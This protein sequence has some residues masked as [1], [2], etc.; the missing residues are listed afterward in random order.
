[1][2]LINKMLQ[3]LDARSVEG[4]RVP[5][6]HG[7]VRA[8]PN[9]RS[10]SVGIWIALGL[11]IV[12]AA[13]ATWLLRGRA[14][15]AGPTSVVATSGA[16]MTSATTPTTTIPVV[17]T[18]SLAPPTV[19]PGAASGQKSIGLAPEF[20]LKMAADLNMVPLPPLLKPSKEVKVRPTAESSPAA[21]PPSSISITLSTSSKAATTPGSAEPASPLVLNR[22]VKDF[23]PQ[24]RAEN[25]Y[26]RATVL[27][28]QG[29]MP[30]AIDTLDQALMLD[31]QNSAARQTLVAL[32]IDSK[33]PDDAIRRMQEGLTLDPNQPALAMVL[34][35][36][37]VEKGDLRLA[38]EA[39]HRSL[40]HGVD[41]PEYL[42]FLAALLQRQGNH[43]EAI[44]R[45]VSALRKQPQNGVWWMGMGI[46]LQAENRIKEAL[47]AFGR[48]K[49]S[50]TLSAELLVY[51]DQKLNQLQQ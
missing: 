47:D 34:A 29:K 21:V 43:K 1:M 31:P 38:V 32:L 28:Q 19:E 10:P 51:V 5:E 18:T 2:S 44:E 41:R 20:S 11:T 37:L 42:A 6:I 12:L 50:N 15:P 24:Q 7:Q 13:A 46:S 16:A 35:R 23:G 30:E 8:V 14:L 36:Q 49:A 27:V 26:R 48:A 22:Q 33:R 40:P 3:D 17:T 39:L 4:T 9:R 45:Y 25:E